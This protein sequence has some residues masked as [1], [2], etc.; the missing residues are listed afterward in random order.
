MVQSRGCR[1]WATL[2]VV[3]SFFPV[4]AGPDLFAGSGVQAMKAGGAVAPAHDVEM[5]FVHTDGPEAHTNL[6]TP[7]HLKTLGMLP[8]RGQGFVRQ[9]IDAGATPLRPV[10]G[11]GD[12]GNDQEQPDHREGWG[13][14]GGR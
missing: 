10:V 13:T 5:A 1:W 9:P 11:R 7:Y 12:G 14:C 4:A 8:F 6:L 3:E 2:H